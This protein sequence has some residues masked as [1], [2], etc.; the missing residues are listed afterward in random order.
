MGTFY[1]II[2]SPLE[3]R[4]LGYNNWSAAYAFINSTDGKFYSSAGDDL[5]VHTYTGDYTA[6]NAT[7]ER[8]TS[9]RF[10]K[11]MFRCRS[12]GAKR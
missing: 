11:R 3:A 4:H 7:R 1:Y 2:P 9:G 8:N 6:T 12:I 5:T 10:L